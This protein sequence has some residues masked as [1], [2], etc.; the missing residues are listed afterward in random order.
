[1][2]LAATFLAVTVIAV[3]TML[4]SPRMGAKRVLY[5]LAPDPPHAFGYDMSWIAVLTSDTEAV[6]DALS[7]EG[8]TASNWNNGIGT[9]YDPWLGPDKVFVSPPVDGWTFVVSLAL[10]H[11]AGP[12]YD[13]KCTP[14]LSRLARSFVDV[15]YF[16]SYPA[17]ESYSWVRWREGRLVRAFASTDEGVIWSKG[18]TSRAEQALGLKLFEFRGVRARNGD[19]G[20]EILMSPTQEQVM[21]IARSWSRDP[22][23]LKA[24]DAAAALGYVAPAPQSWRPERVRKSAA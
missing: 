9:V 5:E 15:Q 22:T 11:P 7:I 17:Q 24:D 3:A 6:L 23:T 21:Q 12:G 16:V 19:A 2:I 8:E 18:P 4:L 14:L 13:D 20:G 1:M 10:P